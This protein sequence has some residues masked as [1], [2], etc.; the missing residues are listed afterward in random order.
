[1]ELAPVRETKT[2]TSDKH[3]SRRIK[4]AVEFIRTNRRLVL[5]F[6]A[7]FVERELPYG[8]LHEISG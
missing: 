6:L 7:L 4:F 8:N 1:M 3:S 2:S 5:A